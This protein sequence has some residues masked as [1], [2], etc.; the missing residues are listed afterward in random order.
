ML[1]VVV[2]GIALCVAL[3]AYLPTSCFSFGRLHEARVA[4]LPAGPDRQVRFSQVLIMTMSCSAPY[5]NAAEILLRGAP[6]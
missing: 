4:P 3:V 2:V 1:N 5:V 6:R